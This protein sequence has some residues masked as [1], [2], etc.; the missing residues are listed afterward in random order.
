MPRMLERT[1]LAWCPFCEYRELFHSEDALRRAY[2]AHVRR[3][4]EEAFEDG[5]SGKQEP[6][7]WMTLAATH[8]QRLEAAGHN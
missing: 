8:V 6:P 4:E 7:Q 1:Y 5:Y 2:D 3:H